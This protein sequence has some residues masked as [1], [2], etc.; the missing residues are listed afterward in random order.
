[1]HAQ[2][3]DI[4]GQVDEMKNQISEFISYMKEKQ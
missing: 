2:V 4:K 1:M 3:V